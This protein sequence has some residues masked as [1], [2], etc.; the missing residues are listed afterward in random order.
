MGVAFSSSLLGLAGSLL[1]FFELQAGGA[2]NR[3]VE[4]LELA[5]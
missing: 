1:G 3:F 4:E 5:V 2:Q